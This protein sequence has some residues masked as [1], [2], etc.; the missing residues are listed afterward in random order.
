[1]PNGRRRRRHSEV[2][3]SLPLTEHDLYLG[4]QAMNLTIV[5]SIIEEMESD[6]LAKYIRIERMPVMSVMC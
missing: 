3:K 5:D 2:L 1:V 6:L 4:M